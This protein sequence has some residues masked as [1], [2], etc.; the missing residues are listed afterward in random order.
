VE[1]SEVRRSN[2]LVYAAAAPPRKPL[3][4]PCGLRTRRLSSV[5]CTVVYQGVATRNGATTQEI[6]NIRTGA[7]PNCASTAF[8]EESKAGMEPHYVCE[9]LGETFIAL[10]Y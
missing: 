10:I 4:Y 9:E 7:T 1:F 5:R 8:S 3:L 6:L 2:R